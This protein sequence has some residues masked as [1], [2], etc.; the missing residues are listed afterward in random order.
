MNEKTKTIIIFAIFGLLLA[1]AQP[2]KS[3]LDLSIP[4]QP[5]AKFEKVTFFNTTYYRE[6]PTKAQT[7]VFWT[8][9]ALDAYTTYEGLKNPNVHEVNPLMGSNP[10]LGQIIAFKAITGKLAIDHL[11]KNQIHGAN[12]L[13][14]YAIYNNNQIIKGN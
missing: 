1:V 13:L 6:P 5:A 14:T 7:M 4:E 9:T 11:S 8:L 3:E 12:A 2:I 10:S